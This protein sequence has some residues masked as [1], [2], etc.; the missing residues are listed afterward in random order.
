LF[1]RNLRSPKGLHSELEVM[2]VRQIESA[3][4]AARAAR[5]VNLL[6]TISAGDAKKK[7]S[8]GPDSG[9]TGVIVRFAALEKGT[10]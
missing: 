3:G 4:D 8:S 9:S 2:R 6:G 10:N 5:L 1:R 7:R